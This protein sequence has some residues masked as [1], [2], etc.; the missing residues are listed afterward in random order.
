MQTALSEQYSHLPRLPVEYYRGRAFV[1][2]TMTIEHRRT[3]WLNEAFHA[4]FRE[5][6]LHTLARHHLVC[7]VYCL[8]P[9]HLH[10]M[11]AGLCLASD[12]RLASRFF[13][14]HLNPALRPYRL[15]LQAFDHVLR[16]AERGREAFA[17]ASG[18]ILQNPVRAGLCESWQHYPYSG[19]MAAG[20]PDLDVRQPDFWEIFW[21][22]YNRLV[23]IR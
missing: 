23:T 2:W 17:A 8:M 19:A 12:Q 20:Y 1:H 4:R 16:L 9:D 21:K 10:M 15:Q 7:P 6:L 13:R 5:I 3:S 14:T 22:L 11:W 18:Y